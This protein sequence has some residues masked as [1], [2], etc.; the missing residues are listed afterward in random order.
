MARRTAHPLVAA[1]KCRA[2]DEAAD[3]AVASRAALM[4]RD[5][6]ITRAVDGGASYR[7]V[8]DATGIPHMTVKRI[9]DRVTRPSVSSDNARL[10]LQDA[11]AS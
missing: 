1:A 8:A 5:A 6:A 7:E 9:V 11:R 4:R 2:L 10:A 3:A